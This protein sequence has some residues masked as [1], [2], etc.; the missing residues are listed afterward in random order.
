MN[1]ARQTDAPEPALRP[2]AGSSPVAWCVLLGVT[3]LS[4]VTDLWS[5]AWAFA[6]VAGQ[7][8]VLEREQVIA[9]SN[10]LR[11][12]GAL[13]PYHDPVTVVPHLLDL[14]LVLNRG[15]VFGMGAGKR[16]FFVVF[17]LFAVIFAIHAFRKW[18]HS[19]QWF[20]HAAIGLVLG[21]GL[22]N[23]YDRL[24]YACVRDFLHPLP[25]VQMPFGLRWPSG[26]SELWPYVSNIADLYLIVGILFLVLHVWRTPH[27]HDAQPTKATGADTNSPTQS[28]IPDS[29]SA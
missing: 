16:W 29:S 8:V 15:A 13:I 26:S 23:L 19:G 25:G 28:D 20:I 4:L 14:T 2:L 27:P 17:T 21:G 22:G 11:W 6:T 18:T 1:P 24:M 9:A 7:P 10:S 12:P 5:K 3:V